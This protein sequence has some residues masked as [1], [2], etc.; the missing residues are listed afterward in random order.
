MENRLPAAFRKMLYRVFGEH[1]ESGRLTQKQ[2]YDVVA[3]YQNSLQPGNWEK[4][5]AEASEKLQAL[6]LIPQKKSI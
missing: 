6:I 5:L 4:Y 3:E 2:I 1:I